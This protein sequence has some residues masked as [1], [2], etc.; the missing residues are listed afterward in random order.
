MPNQQSWPKPQQPNQ[1]GDRGSVG[2]TINADK[3]RGP[4]IRTDAQGN[5]YKSRDGNWRVD[6]TGYHEAG[7]GR[8][9]DYGVGVKVEGRFRRDVLDE[10]VQV[11]EEE[12]DEMLDEEPHRE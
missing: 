3:G 8:K 5:I 7:R 11:Q 2:V 10:E 4:Q 1:P 9:P 6:G 12:V